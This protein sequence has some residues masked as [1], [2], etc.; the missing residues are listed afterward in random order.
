MNTPEDRIADL[1][2]DYENGRAADVATY[3]RR[4]AD[5]AN[6]AGPQQQAAAACDCLEERGIEAL[7]VDGAD[8]GRDPR[9]LVNE[10]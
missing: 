9:G 10:G 2:A 7:S 6:D 3:R 8:P 1:I 5:H 4:Q